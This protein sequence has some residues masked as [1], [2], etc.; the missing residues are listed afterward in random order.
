MVFGPIA[1]FVSRNSQRVVRSAES[2]APREAKWAVGDMMRGMWR[3]APT[4][5]RNASKNRGLLATTV[6]DLKGKMVG[7]KVVQAEREI[8][9][10]PVNS[11]QLKGLSGSALATKKAEILGTDEAMAALDQA[12]MLN[13]NELASLEQNAI[14]SLGLQKIDLQAMEMLEK[15]EGRAFD[16]MGKAFEPKPFWKAR[17]LTTG[18]LGL[19]GGAL[20][21][22]MLARKPGEPLEGDTAALGSAHAAEDFAT[23]MDAMATNHA[24]MNPF[25]QQPD[26]PTHQIMADSAAYGGQLD[27]AM[28]GRAYS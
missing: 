2:L 25:A 6:K 22:N 26:A 9:E 17:P 15:A 20:A 1:R 8:L 19:G 18:A 13:A 12:R 27:P 24:A 10:L 16:H 23:Q 7:Q 3:T 14:E 11:E 28:M 5:M 4:A 21:Y